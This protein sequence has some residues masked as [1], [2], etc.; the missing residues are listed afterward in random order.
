MRQPKMGG[1]KALRIFLKGNEDLSGSLLG[2]A[3]E[4]QHAASTL[5]DLVQEKF[6]GLYTIELTHEPCAGSAIMLQQVEALGVPEE[7]RRQDWG[8]DAGFI[9]DQFRTRLFEAPSDIIVMSVQPDV[10]YGVWK[11]RRNG[12]SLAAPPLWEQRWSLPLKK[13]FTENFLPIGPILREAFKA[14]MVRLIRVIKEK[15]DA[16]ILIYNASTVEPGDLVH[17]Y[18]RREDSWGLRVHKLNLSVMELSVLEGISFIDVERLVAEHGAYQHVLQTG[19]YSGEVH[20]AIRR[21]VLRVLEDIGFFEARPL[22]MQAGTEKAPC[23]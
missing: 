6:R 2:I 23:C 20:E 10:A 7:V 14:N 17:N 9:A 19:G 16:H 13:W 1:N 5:Q 8:N 21:E 12:Y 15:L 11:H 4:R 22:M 18:Y 3:A